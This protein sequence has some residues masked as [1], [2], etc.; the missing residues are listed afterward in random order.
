MASNNK[1]FQKG[2]Q[3]WKLRK[4]DG[5]PRKFETAEQLINAAIGY[6]DW[7]EKNP[8]INGKQYFSSKI[9]IQSRTTKSL[10]AMSIA[11]L[12]GHV[13]ISQ[14]T[15]QTYREVP[16]LAEATGWIDAIIWEQKF[17]GAAAGALN[18]SIIMRELNLMESVD[19]KSSDGSMTPKV[20]FPTE[21]I[22]RAAN[23]PANDDTDADAEN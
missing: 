18:P 6:F 11:G 13:G 2:N 8:I 21:I 20:P 17:S 5:A 19:L 1:G 15:F 10:R 9:K 23:G 22:I 14:K 3:L 7:V 4:V 16:E 12:C